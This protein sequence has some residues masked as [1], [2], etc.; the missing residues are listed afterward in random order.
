MYSYSAAPNTNDLISLDLSSPFAL[1]NP[2]WILLSGSGSQG[3]SVAFHSL[4]AFNTTHAL[5]FGGDGG[6]SLPSP[7]G[8]DSAWLLDVSLPASPTWLTQPQDWA[9][10][11][12][13]SMRHAAASS[14]GRVWVTG[15]ER[16]DGSN[17]P[18]AGHYVFQPSVPSFD[19][20]PTNGAPPILFGHGAL[21][22]S[23]N[24][25]L[26]FGG[27]NPSSNALA[28]MRTL[29]LVDTSLSTPVWTNSTATGNIPTPRRDFAYTLLGDGRVF[30]HG[31]ADADMQTIYS[32]AA[33]LDVNQNP[34]Q[35]SAISSFEQVGAR[36]DHM[37]VSIGGQVLIGFGERFPLLLSA[38]AHAGLGY[39]LNGP[40]STSLLLYETSDNSWGSSFIPVPTPTALPSNSATNIP[41]QTT[42]QSSSS[43]PANTQSATAPHT[44]HSITPGPIPTKSRTSSTVQPSSTSPALPPGSI[45]HGASSN[46]KGIAIGAVFA[47]L[48]FVGLIVCGAYFALR[49]RRPI[50]RRGDGAAWLIGGEHD[51]MGFDGVHGGEPKDIPIA[52]SNWQGLRSPRRQW[53]LLGLGTRQTYG[54]QRFDI[55]HD[56]DIR[57]FGDFSASRTSMRREASTGSGGAWGG[58][59]NASTSSFRSVGA[60]LG[61]GRTRQ[62]SYHSVRDPD[63][64]EKS[65]SN[66][67]LDASEMLNVSSGSGSSPGTSRPRTVRQESSSSLREV[68]YLNPFEDPVHDPLLSR[69]GAVPSGLRSPLSH[70]GLVGAFRQQDLEDNGQYDHSIIPASLGTYG[71]AALGRPRANS[72]ARSNGSAASGNALGSGSASPTAVGSV[73]SHEYLSASL[74]NVPSAPIRR[75]DSWWSRFSRSSLRGDRSSHEF[76]VVRKLSR[77]SDRQPKPDTSIGFRDPAPPPP[78]RPMAPIRES[79]MTPDASPQEPP[80]PR[81]PSIVAGPAA[82]HRRSASSLV[83]VQTAD[84]AALERMGQIDVVRR[85]RTAS[86]HH[87]QSLSLDTNSDI[88]EEPNVAEKASRPRLSVVPGSPS[89]TATD[90]HRESRPST[91]SLSDDHG[92]IIASPT[93][94]SSS[95]GHSPTRVNAPARAVTPRR[96][97]GKV[98]ERIA[99]Y[100]RRMT[101]VNTGGTSPRK[102]PVGGG[103]TPRRTRVEYGLVQRPELFIAN[104]D[105]RHSPST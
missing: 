39:G 10:E 55:L 36:R 102:S 61:I 19:Q 69:D 7:S 5:A 66:P 65:A 26:V 86:T 16:A 11:P 3:P 59:L 12:V 48:V 40:A 83:T 84:S 45:D 103:E 29:W 31:G 13:R 92:T 73:S 105:E 53:T 28:D 82:V 33:I 20:L 72:D 78:L 76:S 23:S 94:L 24:L 79:S 75:S 98:A 58:I 30:I 95:I 56:E 17:L 77:N 63:S 62:S 46:L 38:V 52:G 42:Q 47:V 43:Q 97:T 104:P 89:K 27:Y 1:S 9:G 88:L 25:L 60:A 101:E 91:P 6:S 90:S 4:T 34:M 35:W 96:A 37:A 68:A 18:V 71:L 14:F 50:W 2:P 49:K 67:F 70:E 44:S 87:T 15:G 51:P 54:R 41:S 81:P 100:E 80:L 85:T 22:L 64:R 32:D 21:R 74:L 99:D 8:S 57:E 93:E